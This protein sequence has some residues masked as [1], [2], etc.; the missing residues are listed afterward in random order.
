[1]RRLQNPQDSNNQNQSDQDA[2]RH[3]EVSFRFSVHRLLPAVSPLLNTVQ[4]YGYSEPKS[5]SESKS[6]ENKK[7]RQQSLTAFFRLGV[8]LPDGELTP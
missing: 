8:P 3:H 7:S 5:V 2:D 6:V 1:V 4:G